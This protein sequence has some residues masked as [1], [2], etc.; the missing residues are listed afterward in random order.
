VIYVL[1][2]ILF[3]DLQLAKSSKQSFKV[4]LVV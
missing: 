1:E 4:K 3:C 2:W